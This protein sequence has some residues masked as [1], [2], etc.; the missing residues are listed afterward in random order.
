MTEQTQTPAVAEYRSSME[1]FIAEAV[2]LDWLR[3][4]E[5]GKSEKMAEVVHGMAELALA[6]AQQNL[7]AHKAGPWAEL[8]CI[9]D[10]LDHFAEHTRAPSGTVPKPGQKGDFP[11]VIEGWAVHVTY[12]LFCGMT[13]HFVFRHFGK[14]GELAPAPYAVGGYRSHHAI[15]GLTAQLGVE[16]VAR[17]ALADVWGSVTPQELDRRNQLSLF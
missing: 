9:A 1:Y 14:N 7:E 15:D 2:R 8:D 13:D 6:F 10:W 5:Y 12:R 3:I 11:L 4:E 16:E 17:Q